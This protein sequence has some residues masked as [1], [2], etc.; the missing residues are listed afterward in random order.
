MRQLNAAQLYEARALSLSI[1]DQ[2]NT[3]ADEAIEQRRFADIGTADDG[4]GGLGH[5]AEALPAFFAAPINPDDPTV[6][7]DDLLRFDPDRIEFADYD[8]EALHAVEGVVTARVRPDQWL[9]QHQ[10]VDRDPPR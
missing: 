1:V 10:V 9:E 8:E 4:D 7:G 3:L 2:R 6:A 5:G